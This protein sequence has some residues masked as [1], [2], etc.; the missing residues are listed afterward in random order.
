MCFKCCAC[1]ELAQSFRLSPSKIQNDCTLDHWTAKTK[2]DNIGKCC[3]Y[4]FL[5]VR[6]ARGCIWSVGPT[7]SWLNL[8]ACVPRLDLCENVFENH[9]DSAFWIVALDT[10]LQSVNDCILD[11]WN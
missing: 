2:G 11:N 9:H 1:N 10:L 3:H 6:G 4:D 5:G 7:M 8:S